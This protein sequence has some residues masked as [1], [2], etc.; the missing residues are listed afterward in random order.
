MRSNAEQ[1]HSSSS[2]KAVSR[3]NIRHEGKN[4]VVVSPTHESLKLLGGSLS[5]HLSV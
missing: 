3:E 2:Q 1:H 5:I 4:K